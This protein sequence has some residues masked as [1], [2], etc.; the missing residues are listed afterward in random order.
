MFE[1]GQY[2]IYGR[3]GI[4]KVE[5]ITHLSIA[6]ADKKKL[7]YVLAPLS[8]KGSKVYFPVEK[9]KAH[10]REL[11][12]E[13]EAWELLDEIRDIKEIRVS[14]EKFRE[15]CPVWTGEEDGSDGRTGSEDDRR[16]TV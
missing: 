4:C 7:Y 13:A 10:A 11:I 8:S 1:K 3:S 6:G 9:K 16:G 14:N 12:T 15:E 2:I 5:D